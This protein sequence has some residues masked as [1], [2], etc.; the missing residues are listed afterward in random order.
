MAADNEDVTP[1]LHIFSAATHELKERLSKYRLDSLS[2]ILAETNSVIAC[3]F[4]LQCIIGET[5]TDSNINIF[6][7]HFLAYEY[8]GEYILSLDFA[9]CLH[10]RSPTSSMLASLE[11]P[12]F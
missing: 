1:E 8:I 2:S 3:S 5:W 6:C 4:P 10:L 7:K 11:T 12:T 9:R